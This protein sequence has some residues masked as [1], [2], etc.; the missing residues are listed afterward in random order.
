[1]FKICQLIINVFYTK[2]KNKTKQKKEE[3]ER[4]IFSFCSGIYSTYKK[5]NL[6]TN[7]FSYNVSLISFKCYGFRSSIISLRNILL[8]GNWSYMVF[9]KIIP[10]N[11]WQYF[12]LI[13]KCFYFLIVYC[14]YI[15]II[16]FLQSS[17]VSYDILNSL[18]SLVAVF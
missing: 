6:A 14:Q 9:V 15:K 16:G 12:K 1:M 10:K 3:E 18:I 5:K 7:A 17:L 4:K 11:F 13:F 8:S 2:S